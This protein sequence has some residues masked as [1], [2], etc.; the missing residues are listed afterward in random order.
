MSRMRSWST[1]GYCASRSP[2][3]HSKTNAA[4]PQ[5]WWI[6]LARLKEGGGEPS[7]A[8]AGGG[9]PAGRPSRRSRAASREPRAAIA[10]LV[11]RG[12]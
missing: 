2:W 1:W 12:A 4:A 11:A 7:A 8:S 5:A 6:A 10:S 3:G 9:S